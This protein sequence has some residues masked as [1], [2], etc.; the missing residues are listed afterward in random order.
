MNSTC[1]SI[2]NDNPPL[3]RDLNMQYDNEP[4]VDNINEMEMIFIFEKRGKWI[5]NLTVEKAFLFVSGLEVDH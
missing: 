3:G 4:A 2:V 1:N 5:N